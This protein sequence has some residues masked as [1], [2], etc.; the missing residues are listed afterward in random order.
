[1][2]ARAG[3]LIA[4]VIQFF[5]GFAKALHGW[6]IPCTGYARAD[7]GIEGSG[8]GRGSSGGGSGEG[9]LLLTLKDLTGVRIAQAFGV[10]QDWVRLW[11]GA[12]ARG[13][14]PAPVK[15]EAALRVLVPLLSAPVEDRRN[16]TLSRLAGRIARRE[17]LHISRSQLPK[18][19][20][21]KRGSACRGSGTA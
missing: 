12:F 13:A 5:R 16:G 3:Q 10:R 8:A 21:K 1:M 19:L 9:A 11:R 15:A 2:F 7:G 14:G 6:T 17:G 20:R 4:A 18:V